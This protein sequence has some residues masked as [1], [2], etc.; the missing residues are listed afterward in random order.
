MEYKAAFVVLFVE[1]IAGLA[2]FVLWLRRKSDF[3]LAK[4]KFAESL[5]QHLVQGTLLQQLED[6][7]VGKISVYQRQKSL[8]MYLWMG[9]SMV[10][11]VAVI[12][13]LARF[14]GAGV[15]I[16]TIVGI[17]S[18]LPFVY[19]VSIAIAEEFDDNRISRFERN[20]SRQFLLKSQDQ[21]IE[22]DIEEMLK[23]CRSVTGEN[24]KSADEITS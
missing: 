21:T 7:A 15:I 20:T 24:A 9:I 6:I 13:V 2:V 5:K 17:L 11:G 12:F 16:R 18:I 23:Q 22:N 14:T 4:E 10:L 19:F 1:L 3:N 8:K